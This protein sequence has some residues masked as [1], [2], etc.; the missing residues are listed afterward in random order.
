MFFTLVTHVIRKYAET[1]T[2][3][4]SCIIAGTLLVKDKCGD[5]MK[6]LGNER[7]LGI[8]NPENKTKT[9]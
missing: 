6:S 3:Q 4:L 8:G 2:K 7:E 9:K 1:G 5:P